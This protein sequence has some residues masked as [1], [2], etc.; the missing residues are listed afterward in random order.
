MARLSSS[1]RF[2]IAAAV[3]VL[4]SFLALCEGGLRL[5]DIDARFQNRLFVLNRALDYPEVFE[6]DRDLFWRLRPSQTI[7]SQFFEGK[8]YTINAS[9]FRGPE[10][11]V[12][13]DHER[14]MLLGNSCLFGWGVG[15]E[16][17]TAG[18]LQRQLGKDYEVV[19]AAVPGY[20]SLQGLRS[21]ERVASGLNPDVIVVMFGWNDQWA[22]ANQTSD[23]DQDLGSELLIDLQNSLGRLQIYRLLKKLLLSHV[24]PP[25]DSLFDRA[26]PVYRVDLVSYRQTLT[27]IIKM[28]RAMGARVFLVTEPQ[29]SH[30]AYGAAVVNHPAVR[31]HQRYNVVVREVAQKLGVVLIDAA[32]AFDTRSDLYDDPRR[33][34]IHFNAGGHQLLADLI[35]A[36]LT[37]DGE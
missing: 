37:R 30:L 10:I 2:K 7:T 26:A 34:F 32:A 33:D 15:W 8:T 36:E 11:Q 6:R 23:I 4:L 20:S 22:A 12:D 13:D 25:L 16:E 24:E 18:Q 14:I 3:L 28:A 31:N 1:P 27:D 5:L 19:N 21:L 9:G 17:S 35:A 29:P